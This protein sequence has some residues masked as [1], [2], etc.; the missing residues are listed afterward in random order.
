[1]EVIGAVSGLITVIASVTAVAKRLNEV[2]D[3]YNN[4]ALNTT[5]VAS[6]ASG[7]LARCETGSLTKSSCQR[8][9]PRFKPSPSGGPQ[10]RLQRDPPG[11]STMTWPSPSIAAQFS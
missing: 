8:S 4:V 10:T 6:Q 11:N 7:S 1:M 9:E 2:R 5:L 3:K